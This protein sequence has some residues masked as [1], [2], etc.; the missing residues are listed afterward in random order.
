MTRVQNL[1]G[2]QSSVSNPLKHMPGLVGSL[3]V[4]DHPLMNL[5]IIGISIPNNGENNTKSQP[6]SRPSHPKQ[7]GITKQLE[8]WW[9]LTNFDKLWWTLINFDE[10]WTIL[11]SPKTS[12]N[13][14]HQLNPQRAPAWVPKH[15]PSKPDE[16][17]LPGAGEQGPTQQ[18]RSPAKQ[19][20]NGDINHPSVCIYWY[21]LCIYIYI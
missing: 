10:L 15:P 3:H 9:I 8:C 4:S 11:K 5:G 20:I 18:D 12:K 1:R 19:F 17:R 7:S 14:F 21:L 16:L 2:L 6:V 13:S